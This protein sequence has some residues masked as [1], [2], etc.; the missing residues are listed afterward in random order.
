MPNIYDQAVEV[1]RRTMTLFFVVDTSGSMYGA[2]IGQLNAA[3]EDAIPEIR[4][5]SEENADA[6]IKI[7][8]LEFSSGARWLTPAPMDVT[9]YSWNF[10]DADGETHLGAAC[11]ELNAKL[12]RNAFMDD[13]AGSF[14]PAILLFTDG[15]PTDDYKKPLEE[16]KNNNWFKKAIKIAIA[17]GDDANK[18][19]LKEFTG[20]SETVLTVHTPEALR[21]LIR[22]VSVTASQIGSKS[23]SV[24]NA[25]IDEAGSKQADMI[26]QI[27][28][29]DIFDDADIEFD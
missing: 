19:V 29:S 7:A 13:A 17:I 11:A 15:E 22:F 27:Q 25:G 23:S 9:D 1:A 2:K 4:R 26:Q 10:L 12:S 21:K 28:A 20:N 5:I 16:L 18:D 6:A 24:G 8:V 14:A 3:V